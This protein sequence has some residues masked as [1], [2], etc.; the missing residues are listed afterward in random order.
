M[1]YD[2]E[3]QIVLAT[4]LQRTSRGTGIKW[5]DGLAS[6]ASWFQDEFLERLKQNAIPLA[7]LLITLV[8]SVVYGPLVWRQ[9][10]SR[11]RVGRIRQSTAGAHE[12]TV[13]YERMLEILRGRGIEK[14]AWLTPTEFAGMMPQGAI[15]PIVAD[16]TDAY[17]A[18][19]FGGKREAVPRM[20]ELIQR[21]AVTPVSQ[22]T[23]HRAKR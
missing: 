4:S 1:S 2:L 13:L 5:L 22:D 19:R 7:V 11:W 10:R 23:I 18:L 14:P 17:L 16:F 21:L 3:H 6:G 8:L 15:A 9:A 20:F 12:A